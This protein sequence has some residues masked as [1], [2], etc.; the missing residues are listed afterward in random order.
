[1]NL[2]QV[3]TKDIVADFMVSLIDLPKDAYIV[4]P[5]FG[6]GV[7][8]KSL[9]KENFTNITGVEID[10]ETFKLIDFDDYT[11]C[12]LINKDFFQFLTRHTFTVRPPFVQG[13]E[14]P[15]PFE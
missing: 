10:P 15:V 9:Q 7:F 13:L 5:C 12:N 4:D 6:R 8:V 11:G 2:G 14:F 3:Y 1:M